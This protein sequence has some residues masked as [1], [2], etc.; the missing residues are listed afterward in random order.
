MLGEIRLPEFGE[1]K[2]NVL[3]VSK[4]PELEIGDLVIR[5][6]MSMLLLSE[7]CCSK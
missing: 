7:K 2:I 6:R 5:N 3:A 1:E 4:T